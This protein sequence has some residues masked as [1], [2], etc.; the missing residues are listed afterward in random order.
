MNGVT[1]KGAA[2]LSGATVWKVVGAQDINRDGHSD[3]WWQHQTTGDVSVWLMNGT[4]WFGQVP[5]SGSTLWRE[6]GA[7][8]LNGDGILDVLWQLPSTGEL[9][10]WFMGG[11]G[12]TYVGIAP[13]N[14]GTTWT[15]I[16]TR[17]LGSAISNVGISIESTNQVSNSQI[18]P[19]IQ[20][21][22][23]EPS[24][25][26]G[27]SNWLSSWH[28]IGTA[29]GQ[30]D[31]PNTHAYTSAWA[32]GGWSAPLEHRTPNGPFPPPNDGLTGNRP[33]MDTYTYWDTNRS[34]YWIVA[35]DFNTANNSVWAR[36][37]SDSLG[38]SWGPMVL[39]MPGSPY[40][41]VM[42]DFPSIAANANTGRI[43]V[44]ASQLTYTVNTGYY[45]SYSDNGGA[46]WSTP[47]RVGTSLGATSRIVWS[48]SGF[49]AFIN[50]TAG[51]PSCFY[52]PNQACLR[53]THWQS[54]DGVTWTQQA[55]IATYSVPLFNSQTG[56][57]P[58]PNAGE[59]AYS[60][61]PDAVSSPGLGWVVA[62]P[63]NIGGKNGIIVA[64]ELGG[65][66]LI[67]YDY[68]LFDH[69]ITT[70]ATGDWYLTYLTYLDGPTTSR[71]LQ[72]GALYRLPGPVAG[73]KGAVI[74]N[75][76]TID[77]ANW[78]YYND[79]QG[80]CLSSS[81]CYVAGDW[82][83]P[84]MNIFTGASVP[85]ILGSSNLNDLFQSFIIDPPVTT[86]LPEFRPTIEKFVRGSN[87]YSRGLLTAAHLKQ[88]ASG[89]FQLGISSMGYAT[90]I[91]RGVIH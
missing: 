14:A 3:I 20:S 5:I 86:K 28:D 51:S 49:H 73:Y 33:L 36:M 75:S 54:P 62:L 37:S 9:V 58:G 43:L 19:T 91:N 66:T 40:A 80:R 63:V 52:T 8:D 4:A 57:I 60:V 25:A 79:A 11:S 41:A 31:A 23:W 46:S 22:R 18:T 65:D 67:S 2:Q 70:S 85:V 24:S 39:A 55:D 35:V 88:I 27:S 77:P 7:E 68:D 61:T 87:I 53:L 81:K 13:L 1:Y 10:V 50:E 26:S 29:R 38:L 59:I 71:F 34:K 21:Y 16:G 44:G 74:N 76:W 17:R 6:A 12:W 32:Q 45:T 30:A 48:S 72:Q 15:A 64:T 42:W 84:A 90:L 69:G 47:V 89:R 82:F 56:L 83:R 78:F